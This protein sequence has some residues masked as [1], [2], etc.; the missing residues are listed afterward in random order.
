VRGP[1]V[2]AGGGPGGI[3]NVAFTKAQRKDVI[4]RI[5]ASSRETRVYQISPPSASS[6]RV[7]TI[8]NKRAYTSVALQQHS[9]RQGTQAA[10]YGCRTNSRFEIRS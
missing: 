10:I 4:L 5:D 8:N 2:A 9:V 7:L 1:G 6:S 3:P